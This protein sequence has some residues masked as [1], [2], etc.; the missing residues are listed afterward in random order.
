MATTP[1]ARPPLRR[2]AARNREL[3]IKAAA[4]AFGE[5]GLAASVNAIATAAGVNVATL[6]RNFPTKDHLVGAV[7]E[8]VLEPLAKASQRALEA[9]DADGVLATFVRDSTRGQA[10]HRGVADALAGAQLGEAVVAELR[11]T[12]ASY[13]R[14]VVDAAHAAG[15]L[16]AELDV[17][18]VLITLRM[19]S[20]VLAVAEQRDREID[21]YVDLVIRGLRPD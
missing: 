14:P 4:D 18:D 1:D 16:R 19:L 8:T 2:D 3:L 7:L 20:T 10:H 11:A 9:P 5:D 12:A 15:E 6:Y 21:T 17:V 13:V